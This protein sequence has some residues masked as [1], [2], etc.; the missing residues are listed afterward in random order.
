MV[1]AFSVWV[2]GVGEAGWEGCRCWGIGVEGAEC[3][4][5][6]GVGAGGVAIDVQSGSGHDGGGW[7][8]CYLS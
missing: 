1:A 5:G 8:C 7:V 2:R 4:Y 6:C 3:V